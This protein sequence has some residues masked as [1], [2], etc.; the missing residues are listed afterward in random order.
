MGACVYMGMRRHKHAT[1]C[2]VLDGGKERERGR[3]K[4]REREGERK[5]EREREK[6]A[7]ASLVRGGLWG[8][9]G[10]AVFSRFFVLTDKAK[11]CQKREKQEK[12]KSQNQYTCVMEMQEDCISLVHTF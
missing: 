7:C 12:R 5:R 3:E 9:L 2:T 4:E 1:S 8:S 10:E 6:L 11:F